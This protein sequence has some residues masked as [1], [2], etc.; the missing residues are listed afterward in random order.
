MPTE[1][2]QLVGEVVPTYANRGRCVVS[3]TDPPVVSLGKNFPGQLLGKNVT[4]ER[5]GKN[6]PGSAVMIPIRSAAIRLTGR[7][8]KEVIGVQTDA[9]PQ[10][11]HQ[12]LPKM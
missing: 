6:V 3:A 8:A 11:R 4:E 9:G 5:L 12:I 2:P 7:Q 10:S 1:R